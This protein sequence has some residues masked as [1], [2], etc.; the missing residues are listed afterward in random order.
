MKQSTNKG[1]QTKPSISLFDLRS[2]QLL[3]LAEPSRSSIHLVLQ[4]CC[5]RPMQLPTAAVWST[6]NEKLLAPTTRMRKPSTLA[7]CTRRIADHLAGVDH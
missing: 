6:D 5:D 4:N 1:L 3:G 2:S 7:S